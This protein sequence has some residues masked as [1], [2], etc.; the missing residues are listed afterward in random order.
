MPF[1]PLTNSQDNKKQTDSE[2]LDCAK[3]VLLDVLGE[4]GEKIDPLFLKNR[5]LTVTCANLEIATELR[6]K[7]D[8]IVAKINE[9]LGK[10]EVDRIRYLL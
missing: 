6:L 9:K 5:T 7:T 1:T 3:K 4:S 10:N 8:E 2:L